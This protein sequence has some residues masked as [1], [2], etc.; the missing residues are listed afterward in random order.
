VTTIAVGNPSAAKLSVPEIKSD[1]IADSGPLSIKLKN[2]SAT[3]R[4]VS[5][6]VIVPEGLEA[7]DQTGTMH[8]KGWGEDTLSITV[9]NRTALA[10]SRY[11]VFVA[12][13]YDDGGMHQSVVAQG[14]VEI[15]TPRNFWEANQTL[16]IGGAVFLV[17]VWLVLVLRGTMRRTA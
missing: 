9:V 4:D 7:T 13:E 10:G 11:P 8:L 5:Y 1:G 2:L 17:A 15:V 12:A 14:I 6:R 3:E 16:L